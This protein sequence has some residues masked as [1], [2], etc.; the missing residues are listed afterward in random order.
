MAVNI[1]VVG[2]LR[3]RGRLW[4]PE[5]VFNVQAAVGWVSCRQ[6]GTVRTWP[7]PSN[8]QS[9]GWFVWC[10]EG[11]KSAGRSEH[12]QHVELDFTKDNSMRNALVLIPQSGPIGNVGEREKAV[13]LYPACIF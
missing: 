12:S 4:F 6:A 2:L 1:G 11:K 10:S 7:G 8:L 3:R 5:D 9:S 13:A